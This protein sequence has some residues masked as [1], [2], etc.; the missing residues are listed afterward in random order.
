MPI[1]VDLIVFDLDGTLADSLPDLAKAANFACRAL[2]LPEHAVEVIQGMIGG[3]EANFVR[4]FLGLENQEYFD[5]ALALYLDHYSRHL[6]DFTRLY[7]GVKETLQHFAAKKL[8]VLSNKNQRLTERALEVLGILPLFR[9]VRGGGAD[10]SLKPSPEPLAAL[11][12]Q[13]GVAPGRTL[14]VGDKPADV[15]AGQGAGAHTCGVTYGYGEPAALAAAAPEFVISRI[16]ELS[17]I[18][19]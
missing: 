13:L 2:G 7:P 14:M 17:K 5:K 11:L 10:L 9:A 3:G 8:A 15:L 12:R 1:E 4:R 6:G 18:V 19:F 16:T